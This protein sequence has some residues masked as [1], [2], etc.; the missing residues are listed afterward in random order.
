M[1]RAGLG[2]EG[3]TGTMPSGLVFD[4]QKY[5][6]H[7]GPGIRTTVFLKGCPLSCSWCHNPEGMASRREIVVLEN[8]CIAC[9]ECRKACPLA[10]TV[11]AAGP[12]PARVE[13]CA[14]CEQCADAC[15]AGARRV[16]GRE[17]S[18]EE[19]TAEVLQDRLFYD[20]SG[21]GVTFSGGEPFAQPQFLL[22]L[23]EACRS[24]GVRTAV[25]T[26]GFAC[27]DHLLA[28]ASLTDLFLYDVKIM[29]D[30]CHRRHTGISNVP[31][32]E[33]L[34]ALGAAH[35]NIWL[36]VPLVPGITDSGENLK[37]IAA[38]AAS[39]PSVRQIS[40]LPYHPTGI[41]KFRRLGLAYALDGQA[42]PSVAEVENALEKFRAHGLEARVGG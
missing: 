17:M 8:R 5:S 21:G 37:A 28:A 20:D 6:I 4:I 12:L 31:I 27:T 7:D 3:R 1:A 35:R 24:C 19:V 26:C 2:E 42:E 34:R 10:E 13:G 14:L 11:S 41:Q 32:L 29:D 39:L 15:P 18:V 25:D 30:A 22:A 36:R 9:G 38:L 23:L 33:N 40:V 16:A